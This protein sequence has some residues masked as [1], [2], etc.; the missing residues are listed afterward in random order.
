MKTSIFGL[1]DC[2]NFF[3]SCE[4]VFRPD[5]NG[6]PVVVL[7]SNDGCAVARSNEAKALGI[8]MG[9]PAFKYRQLFK[10]HNVVQFSANFELYA[11]MSRRI[12]QILSSEIPHIEVY[13]IDESFLDLS[14]KKAEDIPGFLQALRKRIWRETGI[15]VSIG[16]S[17]TKTLAKLASER[18]K[19]VPELQG[20]L[21]TINLAPMELEAHLQAVPIEDIWG[22]GRRFGP[23]LRGLGIS[24]AL[25]LKAMPLRLAR[26]KMGLRG[27][28]MVRELRDFSCFSLEPEHQRRKSIARTRTFGEDTSEFYVLEAAI[29]SFATQAT[30][31]LRQSKQ[32]TRKAGL[33]LMTNR[34]KPGF[35]Q[36]SCEV[37]F[38]VPTSDSGE[39]LSSLVAALTELYQ[40]AQHY[41]R[42]GVWLHD[43]IP[44]SGLQTDIFGRVDVNAHNKASSRMSTVDAINE[45]FGKHTVHFAAEDLA[46]AWEPQRKLRSPRYVSQWDE[47]PVVKAL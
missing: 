24:N 17:T 37:D 18:G 44:T 38:K 16:A 2:N 21:S 13:S 26:Q 39:L 45:R 30:F 19:K 7:S 34:H 28:Q 23:M 3:V 31:R 36:W 11:D 29:A 4:R 10:R 40:P 42:A 1:V 41:H 14:H 32:L 43:F 8:P 27:E 9:A 33:F 12:I 35:R 22:V 6:K 47:L 25:E 46:K 5:L 15:P 20:T